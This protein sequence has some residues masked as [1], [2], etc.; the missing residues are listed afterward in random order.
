MAHI[1]QQA[2][3]DHQGVIH[4]FL[5]QKTEEETLKSMFLF[6]VV[7]R[8]DFSRAKYGTLHVSGLIPVA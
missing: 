6:C 1:R 2:L 8:C 3:L 7:M 4:I 5:P